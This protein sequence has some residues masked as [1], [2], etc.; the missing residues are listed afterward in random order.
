MVQLTA[1]VSNDFTGIRKEAV[2]LNIFD[3]NKLQILKCRSIHIL[4]VR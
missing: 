2:V 3:K 4:T 1:D